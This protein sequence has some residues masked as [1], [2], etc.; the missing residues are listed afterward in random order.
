MKRVLSLGDISPNIEQCQDGDG[1][2]TQV[3]TRGK[4]RGKNTKKSRLNADNGDSDKTIDQTE[5][6]SAS[7][8]SVTSELRGEIVNLKSQI[9]SLRNQ[10]SFLL[11]YFGLDELPTQSTTSAA[12]N[13]GVSEPDPQSDRPNNVTS[14]PGASDEQADGDRGGAGSQVTFA[15]IARRPPTLNPSLQ[16]AVISA[17]YN[18]FAEHNRRSKNIIINGLAADNV[19]D[20]QRVKRLLSEEFGMST[21]VVMCRRL[22][23]QTDRIQP[24]LVVLPTTTDAA[25]LIENARHLRHSPNTCVRDS[26]YINA[27]LT[28]AEAHAAYQRRCRRREMASTRRRNSTNNAI[29][30]TAGV[31]DQY[32]STVMPASMTG[33]DNATTS[34]V[35]Q[36]QQHISTRVSRVSRVSHGNPAGRP[37]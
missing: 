36:Q 19:D 28:K 26:V 7:C 22:G 33:N 21:D 20:K 37:R 14:E 11:S 6:D 3:T 1:P 17:V 5:H 15:S 23:R 18:D 31:D 24:L 30:D 34:H 35:S 12:P 9:T 10:M 8:V 4:G 2:F 27:D 13:V 16:Q 29:I 25:H 32:Y